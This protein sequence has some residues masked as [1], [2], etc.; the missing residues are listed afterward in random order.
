MTNDITPQSTNIAAS[1]KSATLS[2]TLEYNAAGGG[3]STSNRTPMVNLAAT[4]PFNQM[5]EF[6]IDAAALSVDKNLWEAPS[7]TLRAR[8]VIIECLYGAGGIVINPDGTPVKF[9]LAAS[10][11]LGNGWLIYTNPSGDSPTLTP[12]TGPGINKITVDTETESRFKV[13][14]FV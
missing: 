8:A 5:L 3:S 9:P 4:L 11:T 10:S 2:A 12:A 7:E 13:Y 1:G 14:I 6:L